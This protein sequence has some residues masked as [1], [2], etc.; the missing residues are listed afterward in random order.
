MREYAYI[1]WECYTILYKGLEYPWIFVSAVFLRTNSSRILRGDKN[2][3]CS[4]L[5]LFQIFKNNLDHDLIGWHGT[6]LEGGLRGRGYRCTLRTGGKGGNR[7]WDGWIASLTQNLSK[8][9]EIV[10]DRKAWRAAIHGVAKSWTQ[11][12]NWI[13]AMYYFVIQHKLT[14]HCKTIIL[15]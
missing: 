5:L 10:K 15:E 7:G 3:Y 2:M 11:L 6:E 14:Q 9:R 1:T 4:T 13:I 12:S 8:F